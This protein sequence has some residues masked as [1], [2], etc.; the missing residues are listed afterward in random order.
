MLTT[1]LVEVFK[2]TRKGGGIMRILLYWKTRKK[3]GA[4]NS[5]TE[6]RVVIERASFDL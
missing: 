2:K 6:Y 1:V 4:P 5:D 3:Q